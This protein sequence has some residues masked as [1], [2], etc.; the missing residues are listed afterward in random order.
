MGAETNKVS[1]KIDGN[2]LTF[3]KTVKGKTYT[4]TVTDT[5]GNGIFD[6]EAKFEG[7]SASVFTCADV[8][9]GV[10]GAKCKATATTTTTT[11]TTTPTNP[12]GSGFSEYDY[13]LPMGNMGMGGMQFND[14]A[15]SWLG[16]AGLSGVAGLAAG[17]SARNTGAMPFM[18]N[19]ILAQVQN[20]M[21]DSMPDFGMGFG[22][23]TDIDPARAAMEAAKA[24]AAVD[25]TKDSTTDGDKG[26][27][28][29]P[30]VTTKPD[31][32]VRTD[33]PDG[34]AIEKF[35][36]GCV[37]K[38]HTDKD[39]N[40]ICERYNA[41]NK[42]VDVNCWRADGKSALVKARKGARVADLTSEALR[43]PEAKEYNKK[44]AQE[45]AK[46]KKAQAS[47]ICRELYNAMEGAGTDDAKLK[48]AIAKINKDN[49]LEVL[50]RWSECAYSSEMGESSLI[51]LIGD[52]TDGLS[53]NLRQFGQDKTKSF[54]DPIKRALVERSGS[55]EAK[56]LATIIDV[57]YS[58]TFKWD[59]STA[60]DNIQKLYELVKEEKGKKAE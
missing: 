17:G 47:A 34:R 39:G 2:V 31:G 21:K 16:F 11:K 44:Q 50:D 22:G 45:S 26:G 20:R 24:D 7:K 48:S 51:K 46:A 49:V 42:L 8:K 6:E 57:N 32:T 43:T 30:V 56:D 15:A 29:Q 53:A 41:K 54:L 9:N 33:Y 23:M 14:I 36:N 27:K 59:D 4:A 55:E 5:N 3:T 28:G 37:N 52:E 19:S 1:T 35:P 60:I 38:Y 12:S 13:S 40:R 18:F 10:E 58:K 25:T